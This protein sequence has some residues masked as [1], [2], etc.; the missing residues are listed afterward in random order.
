MRAVPDFTQFTEEERVGYGIDQLGM[1]SE[2]MQDLKLSQFAYLGQW[3]KYLDLVF[4]G[5]QLNPDMPYLHSARQRYGYLADNFSKRCG[6]PGG[7]ADD[8]LIMAYD[9]V[10]RS[11][12]NLER[13]L[14]YACLHPGDS[15]TVGCLAFHLFSLV[16]GGP[17]LDVQTEAWKQET[18][19]IYPLEEL[20]SERL[21]LW[22]DSLYYG[23]YLHYYYALLPKYDRNLGFGKLEKATHLW[24][25]GEL[26]HMDGGDQDPDR[27]RRDPIVRD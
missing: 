6:V 27:R 14:V 25:S 17:R 18:T 3:I 26:S 22:I 9:S 5:D 8:C 12:G 2:M 20:F 16:H 10:L 15:D 19:A 4:V 13:L 21:Y 24:S 11:G 7:C 23:L 1:T